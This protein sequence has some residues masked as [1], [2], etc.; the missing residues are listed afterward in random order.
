MACK[1]DISGPAPGDPAVVETLL[2]ALPEWFGIESAIQDYVKGA[3][4]LD[5]WTAW[6]DDDAMG[7]LLAK[8]HAPQSAEV[9][10][11]GVLPE[12]QGKGIG[13]RLLEAAE[14]HLC[15]A[16]VRFLQV[17]TLSPACEYEPYA[18]TRAFYASR[19]FVPLEEFLSLWGEGNPCLQYVKA[20]APLPHKL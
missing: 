2:R 10:L 12:L 3:P 9:I 4:L 16:G 5:A 20:L 7:M 18:R 14:I 6:L 8:S 1:M 15:A 11:M 17:K 19:G 13:S